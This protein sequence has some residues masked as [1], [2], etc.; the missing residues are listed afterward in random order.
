MGRGWKCSLWR[1]YYNYGLHPRK[2]NIVKWFM[3]LVHVF[4]STFFWVSLDCL[5]LLWA[6]RDLHNEKGENNW[7]LDINFRHTF[8][9]GIPDLA[10]MQIFVCI[11]DALINY[12]NISPDFPRFYLIFLSNP[13]TVQNKEYSYSS[14]L[15]FS[16][17]SLRFCFLF[18]LFQHWLSIF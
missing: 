6:F 15:D 7:V 2:C 8:S 4:T 17:H 3:Q 5:I 14:I 9:F 10:Y 11:T 16:N 1:L 18:I 12:I 13:D